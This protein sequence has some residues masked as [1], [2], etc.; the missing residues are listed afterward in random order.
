VEEIS[1]DVMEQPTQ[2]EVEVVALIQPP[3]L[4]TLHQAEKAVQVLS[5]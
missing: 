4:R 5:Y 3:A 1:T 2:V